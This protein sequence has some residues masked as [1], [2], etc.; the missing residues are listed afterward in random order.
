MPTL[1][2]T[3][4]YPINDSVAVGDEIFFTPTQNSSGAVINTTMH[5]IGNCASITSTRLSLNCTYATGTPTPGTAPFTGSISDYF[6]FFGKNKHANPSGLI[7]YYAEVEF[8]NTDRDNISE[9]FS[10]GSEV[11]ESSK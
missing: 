11:F 3:F 7:G 2:L 1:T 6:I 5:L 9:L 4:A 10:V 8:R